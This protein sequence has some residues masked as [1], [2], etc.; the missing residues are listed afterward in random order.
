MKLYR[1]IEGVI[2]LMAWVSLCKGIKS[3][4]ESW[5]SIAEHHSS[6]LRN[7]SQKRLEHEMMIAINGPEVVHCDSVVKEAIAMYWSSSK[8]TA[9]REGHWV[10]RSNNIKCYTVS[11][12]M[13]SIVT[14][15]PRIP[16]ISQ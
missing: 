11:K 2:S 1:D 10:R 3:I 6:K 15:E 9:N 4:V 13:D 7:L 16:A 8:M 5:V 14:K 12:A